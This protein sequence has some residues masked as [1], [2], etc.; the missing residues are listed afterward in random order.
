MPRARIA[1]GERRPA[2]TAASQYGGQP[3][4]RREVSS[5]KKANLSLPLRIAAVLDSRPFGWP[6]HRNFAWLSF[7]SRTRVLKPVVVFLFSLLTLAL[8]S[9]AW[10]TIS[11]SQHTSKDA[12]TG[13]S[14][15]LAFGSNNAAGNFIAVCIRG[16][17]QNQT[18]TVTDTRNGY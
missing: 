11:L 12:G 15:T 5:L 3:E 13:T 2:S 10:A 18:F 1:F 4:L 6:L 7:F 16:G 8:S 14:S 17:A 9:P